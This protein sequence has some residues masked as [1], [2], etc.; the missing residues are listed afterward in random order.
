MLI[1]SYRLIWGGLFMKKNITV[2]LIFLLFGTACTTA[3]KASEV[4][5]A[6]VPA[7]QYENLSCEELFGAAEDIRSKTASLEIAVDDSRRQDKVKEQV[8]W[9]LFAPA[10][11]LIEGNAEEQ[12]DLALARGQLDA[13]RSAAI[14]A[15]CNIN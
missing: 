14:K 2:I 12:T 1:V 11:F 3:K 8:A 5:A 7:S 6:Y 9:W 13:I 15:R 10:A 4:R